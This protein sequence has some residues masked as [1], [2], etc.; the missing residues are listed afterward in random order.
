[1]LI[2]HSL[3]FLGIIQGSIEP[4]LL[5]D[6]GIGGRVVCLCESQGFYNKILQTGLLKQPAFVFSQLWR[7]ELYH[8]GARR[9]GFW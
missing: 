2:T 7:L 5:F 3:I 6:V 9:A 1:M 8:Q 4:P